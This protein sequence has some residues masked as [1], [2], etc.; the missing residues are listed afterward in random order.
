MNLSKYCIEI[1]DLPCLNHQAHNEILEIFKEEYNNFIGFANI[2]G[3]T[4]RMNHMASVGYSGRKFDNTTDLNHQ[5]MIQIFKDNG[6]RL[7]YE[8]KTDIVLQRVFHHAPPHTDPGRSAGLLYHLKGS[9]TT[10]F[11]TTDNFERDVDYS[12]N[13]LTLQETHVMSLHNWH[14]FNNGAI[15]S[16]E[17]IQGF[18]RCSVA[19]NCNSIF[20]D[21]ET[22]SKKYHSIFF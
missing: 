1:L 8:D 19:I 5:R 20:T 4:V 17:N 11:Y 14:L 21:F 22:A 13:D 9:A 10:H 3:K 7:K 2:N 16:V 12:N 6:L 15:H 18:V